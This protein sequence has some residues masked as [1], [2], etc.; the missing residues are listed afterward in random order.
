VGPEGR[1]RKNKRRVTGM[2]GGCARPFFIKGDGVLEESKHRGELGHSR[3][4]ALGRG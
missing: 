2:G 3:R 1:S 4:K